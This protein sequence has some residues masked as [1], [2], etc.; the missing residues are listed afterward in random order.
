[1]AF[2]LK[3]SQQLI[4]VFRARA[5]VHGTDSKIH[6]PFQFSGRK[7]EFPA[8]FDSPCDLCM[9]LPGLRLVQIRTSIANTDRRQRRF[10]G[11]LEV[12][13]FCYQGVKMLRLAHV[14]VDPFPNLA[15]HRIA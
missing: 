1:M 4:H 11:R 14:V 5:E 9:Q 12:R 13:M 15:C 8:L 6:F 10:T 3:R 7:P 2:L